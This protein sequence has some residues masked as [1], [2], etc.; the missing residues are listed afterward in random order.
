MTCQKD[1]RPGDIVMVYGRPRLVLKVKLDTLVTGNGR[2]YWQY[3]AKD[4]VSEVI[5]R[6]FK[7]KPGKTFDGVP[8]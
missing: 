6:N 3:W 2:G 8:R 1:I 4:Q 5:A 7:L